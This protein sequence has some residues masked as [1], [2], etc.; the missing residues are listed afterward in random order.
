MKTLSRLIFIWVLLPSVSVAQSPA[1]DAKP[2]VEA[3]AFQKGDYWEFSLTEEGTLKKI[4]DFSGNYK[5]LF[6]GGEFK[7]FYK[8]NLQW[9]D[10]GFDE[11]LNI[12]KDL[13]VENKTKRLNF[14]LTEGKKWPI[15]YKQRPR[16]GRGEFVRAGELKV[17]GA[18]P[19]STPAGTFDVLKI[20]G[21]D[22]GKAQ[23]GGI[24]IFNYQIFY[25]RQTKSVVFYEK[26]AETNCA[27]S[28]KQTIRLIA[29]GRIAGGG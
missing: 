28:G 2:E 12:F 16:G 7:L 9:V 6:D 26:E 27:N 23:G 22:R 17:S 21:Q 29:H 19:Q 20:H 5:V 24:C 14:P 1:Q 25:S 15:G 3:P 13:L 4:R 10:T 11:E 18:G 8:E